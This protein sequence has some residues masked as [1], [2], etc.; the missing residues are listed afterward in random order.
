MITG[1]KDTDFITL[2][3]LDDKDFFNICAK[4]NLT[5]NLEKEDYPLEFTNKKIYQ[6]CNNEN[7]WRTRLFERYG[8]FYPQDGQIWKNLYLK[9][10]YY[11][12]KYKYKKDNKSFEDASQNGQ[13]EVV[14]YLI[15]LPKEYKI[16]PSANNNEAIRW[17][18]INGHLEVVKYLMSLPKEY[19]IN[20][21]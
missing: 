4:L 15:S 10:D 7:L 8:K 20:K 18:S 17:A 1:N 14:K 12:D 21:N 3:K 2:L 6:L 9:L 13:L 16:D 11:L 19:N 5:K